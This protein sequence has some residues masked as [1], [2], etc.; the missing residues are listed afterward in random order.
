MVAA[1]ITGFDAALFAWGIY[2]P[3]GWLILAG[4]ALFYFTS[5]A[6]SAQHVRKA[7]DLIGFPRAGQVIGLFGL[8][9]M[10]LM[11]VDSLSLQCTSHINWAHTHLAA[12]GTAAVPT[13]LAL[14]VTLLAGWF[15][16]R[17]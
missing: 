7:A 6:V 13:L 3:D 5:F 16:G 8:W 11:S 17:R 1:P 10:V 12:G 4:S 9:P 15:G 14:S 2:Q